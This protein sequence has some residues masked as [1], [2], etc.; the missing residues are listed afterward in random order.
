MFFESIQLLA[1]ADNIGITGRSENDIKKAFTAL[2]HS[3][4]EIGL[5]VMTRKL[6][7]IVIVK[8]RRICNSSALHLKIM[9]LN[10][11]SV[12]SY[13]YLGSF[14]NENNDINEEINK[15]NH[16]ANRC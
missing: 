16:N 4:E 8:N 10:F 11:G 3:A 15:R 13:L 14:V 1:Y 12:S 5:R 2:Y 7:I 9:N 6:S